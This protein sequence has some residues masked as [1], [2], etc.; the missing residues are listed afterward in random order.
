MPNPEGKGEITM[1]DLVVNSLRMRPDRIIMGEIRRK[2][3]AEVLFEAMHT[4]HS[5][6]GTFHANNAEETVQ[7]LTNPPIDVPKLVLSAMSLVCV[8]NRNRRTGHRRT[9]Q[10]AEIL[11]SGDANVFMQLN[12]HKDM[13]EKV[14]EP[15]QIY[16][17]LKLYTGSTQQEIEDDLVEKVKILKWLVDKGVD[18]VNQIGG[19]FRKYYVKRMAL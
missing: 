6:Y 1:L 3:E 11:P 17:T 10:L 19:I 15:K 16:K 9:L 12:V 5:V 18:D 4:G 2:R 13:L 7:R 8:Q 14:G